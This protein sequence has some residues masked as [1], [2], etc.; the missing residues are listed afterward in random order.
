MY[1]I[2]L[3]GKVTECNTHKGHSFYKK[4]NSQYLEVRLPD[5]SY[6]PYPLCGGLVGSFWVTTSEAVAKEL[7]TAFKFAYNSGRKF[8][9]A[10]QTETWL[11]Q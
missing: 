2:E 10:R 1:V 8:D 9:K 5:G 4:G 7:S 3:N 11:S 6:K